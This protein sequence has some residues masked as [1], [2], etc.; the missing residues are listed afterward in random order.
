[1]I[2]RW[3]V[4]TNKQDTAEPEVAP[5][6]RHLAR[7]GMRIGAAPRPRTVDKASAE[8]SDRPFGE[9]ALGT[10]RPGGKM[11]AF[12]GSIALYY[13]AYQLAVR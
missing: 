11:K 13:R 12:T 6:R 5:I 4:G 8:P 3:A 7:R 9:G 1:M 10:R 2:I